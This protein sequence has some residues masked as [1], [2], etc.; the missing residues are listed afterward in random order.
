MVLLH[1]VE[2]GDLDGLGKGCLLE[3][4]KA[5]YKYICHINLLNVRMMLLA[6]RGI[7]ASLVRYM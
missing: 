5:R 1:R 6:R 4:P 2:C 3:Q 7:A